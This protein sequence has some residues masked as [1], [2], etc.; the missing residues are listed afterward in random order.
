MAGPGPN[1]PWVLHLLCMLLMLGTGSAAS[2]PPTEAHTS[3]EFPASGV[4]QTRVVDVSI[5]AGSW[6]QVG[7]VHPIN[8][9]LLS[10]YYMPGTV[11]HAGGTVG[12]RYTWSLPSWSLYSSG[13]TDEKQVNR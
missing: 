13:D 7:G 8:Q 12:I 5:Q 2:S 4:N 10:T 3:P 11:P 1:L 9:Y 6:H